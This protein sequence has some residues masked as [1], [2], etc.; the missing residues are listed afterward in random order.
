[1]TDIDS[2]VTAMQQYQIE[3]KKTILYHNKGQK[4]SVI[5]RL[6]PDGIVAK[7]ANAVMERINIVSTY[8]KNKSV[9]LYKSASNLK[10]FL[11][12]QLLFFIIFILL[13]TAL[14]Y[15]IL[16]KNIR[17]PIEILTKAAQRFH[18]GDMNARSSYKSQNELGKLSASFNT[19]A[20][21]IQTNTELGEKVSDLSTLMLTEY[22]VKKFFQTILN[23]IAG[24]TNSQMAAIYL[25]SNDKKTFQHFE[26][27]G[28]DDNARKNFSA[29]SYEG[30]FGAAMATRQIQH[31]KNIPENTRFIFHT[32]SGK[33][34]P[35]EII[36]IPII[37]DNEIEAIISLS[38][39]NSYSKQSLQLIES[40]MV[41]LSARVE[42][43]LAYHKIKEFYDK[44]EK[45]NLE[46]EAQKTEL[47]SQSA[48]LTEQNAELEIQK[49]QLNEA[50]RL[51]TSFLSNMSHELRTPLN[52]VIALSGVLNRRLANQIPTEEY[53]YLEVIE[54]NGKHLLELINNILDISRIEAGREEVEI[55]SF[56][57]N[58]V[59]ADVVNMIQPQAKL[60]NISIIHTNLPTD[61]TITSDSV[62][63]VHIIQNLISNAVKFTEKGKVEIAGKLTEKHIEITVSDTGIGIA[64]NHIPHIFDEFRQADGSTSRKYG[65]T[66][67][68]LAIA[69]KYAKLLGGT[70]KATSSINKGSEF[71]LILPLTYNKNNT[72]IDPPSISGFNQPVKQ[73]VYKPLS[74]AS[75]I[76]TILLVEDNESVLIQMKDFL[77]ESKYQIL[78]ANNGSEALQIIDKTIPDAIILDLMMPEIDGFQLL[79]TIRNAE[80]TAHIPV[81]ILTAKH[82]TKEELSFL[83][84]NNIHQL[85][86]K[87]DV[88][89]TELLTAINLSLIHI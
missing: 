81:L 77:E 41:A 31:L 89:R 4:D 88:N 87:G 33:F 21:D 54:R 76:K 2:I 79:E 61:L 68:G 62:K 40:I 1:M 25:L 18:A 6:R 72:I 49:N 37:V 51:K 10:D 78:I 28:V 52:S 46:L 14:I 29:E 82:I 53:S 30:E 45:Q 56:N 64:E 70:I 59:V 7:S 8:A 32:V 84:R 75:S 44:L 36:T 15:F 20:D 69:L 12:W 5:N 48:E 83:H 34:I 3:R 27:L 24:H 67:L 22:D 47:T 9:S 66:G 13:L 11:S 73:S 16:I 71:T 43:I 65:G 26:S 17:N 86:Q 85:I 35:H 23:A 58:A 55:T 19:L 42:G 63:F 80:L 74:S 38:S 60:K 50:N 39:I 57:A